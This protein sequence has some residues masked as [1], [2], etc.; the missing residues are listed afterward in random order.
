MVFFKNS[1]VL[2]H[3]ISGSQEVKG[4]DR[5]GLQTLNP[6]S[7]R[8]HQGKVSRAL[9]LLTKC[10]SHFSQFKN[11]KMLLSKKKNQNNLFIETANLSIVQMY[12]LTS[13]SVA[14]KFSPLWENMEVSS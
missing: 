4:E 9:G 2:S 1:I 10:C 6:L 8:I 7:I 11:S 5:A 3:K 13:V 12:L 14:L